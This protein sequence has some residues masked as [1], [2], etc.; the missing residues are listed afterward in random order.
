MPPRPPPRNEEATE[1]RSPPTSAL[2]EAAEAAAVDGAK[3]VVD[4]GEGAASLQ[5]VTDGVPDHAAEGTSHRAP[6][7]PANGAAISTTSPTTGMA[8]TASTAASVTPPTVSTTTS[9]TSETAS[10]ISS[11]GQPQTVH[12]PGDGGDRITAPTGR[13]RVAPRFPHLARGKGITLRRH[14]RYRRSAGTHRRGPGRRVPERHAATGAV[15]RVRGSGR[16]GRGR[17][18]RRSR[19]R[20]NT[21][22]GRRLL[23]QRHAQPRPRRQGDRPGEGRGGDAGRIRA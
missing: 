22:T 15:V 21:G 2:G 12:L 8:L 16:L 20:A 18:A 7:I 11:N 13:D 10:A 19:R 17:G 14:E 3:G 1:S 4:E 5:D 9:A 23:D 6:T